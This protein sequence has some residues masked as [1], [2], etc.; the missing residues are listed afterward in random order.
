MK[1]KPMRTT[2]RR[3]ANGSVTAEERAALFGGSLPPADCSSATWASM[4]V[5]SV[6]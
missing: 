3:T 6:A 5:M 1:A 2:S 4:T